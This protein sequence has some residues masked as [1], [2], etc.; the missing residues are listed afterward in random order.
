MKKGSRL[1]LLGVTVITP[2][3][4]AGN[5]SLSASVP[6]ANNQQSGALD[7]EAAAAETRLK[8]E[9]I[10]LGLAEK[11]EIAGARVPLLQFSE[12]TPAKHRAVPAAS[13]N[14]SKS[15]AAKPQRMG[16]TGTGACCKST[17]S[18]AVRQSMPTLPST[19]CCSKN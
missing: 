3:L 7:A 2:A 1:S 19:V 11:L 8:A 17:H 14:Q 10:G 16:S 4:T 9:M 15:G 5:G 6:A 18:P 13:A 12:N